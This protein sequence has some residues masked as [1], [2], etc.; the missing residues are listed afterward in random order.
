MALGGRTHARC[1][2]KRMGLATSNSWILALELVLLGAGGRMLVELGD[3]GGPTSVV[4]CG[5]R[6]V[7]DVA[8]KAGGAATG[9][10]DATG[11]TCLDL[12]VADERDLRWRFCH[13]WA[14]DDGNDACPAV[15]RVAQSKA[16]M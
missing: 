3:R 1:N 11:A 2:Q 7:G 10:T 13:G 12:D 9:A 6:S 5:C 8:V 16:L 4:G 14:C 15:D